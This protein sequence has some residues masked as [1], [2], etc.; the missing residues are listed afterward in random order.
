ME[1][2]NDWKDDYSVAWGKEGEARMTRDFT[3]EEWSDWRVIT[4]VLAGQ[5]G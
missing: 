5:E 2:A 1:C 3:S 4:I